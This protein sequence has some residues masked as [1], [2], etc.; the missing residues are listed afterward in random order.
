MHKT[1]MN[2]F[3]VLFAS[4]AQIFLFKAVA[5]LKRCLPESF[6]TKLTLISITLPIATTPRP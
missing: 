6:T 3:G 1:L 2:R 4:N 5:S